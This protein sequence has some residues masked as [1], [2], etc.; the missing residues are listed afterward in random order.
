MEC[1]SKNYLVGGDVV[2]PDEVHG[3]FDL[4]QIGVRVE[5]RIK[6]LVSQ[7]PFS[8]KI[9]GHYVEKVDMFV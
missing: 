5:N 3:I 4:G 1:Q 8:V 2:T 9:V 7:I 6:L